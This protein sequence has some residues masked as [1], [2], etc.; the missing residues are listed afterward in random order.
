MRH[1]EIGERGD[2][3]GGLAQHGLHLGQLAAEHAGGQRPARRVRL[4]FGR[5]VRFVRVSPNDRIVPAAE[6][7][8]VVAE[9]P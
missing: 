9:G 8:C 7:E 4:P 5:D 1:R 6:L 3:L 2:V